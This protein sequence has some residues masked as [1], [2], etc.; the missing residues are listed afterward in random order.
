MMD[1]K[2]CQ[3]KDGKFVEPCDTLSEAAEFGNPRGKQK[4]IWCWEYFSRTKPGPTR[5]FFGTKSGDFTEKGMAF[6]YCPFCG[7]KID[8]P[9]EP[10]NAK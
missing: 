3:V 5:R 9:F 2:K 1:K 4:G 7:E 6:N 8:A 10:H